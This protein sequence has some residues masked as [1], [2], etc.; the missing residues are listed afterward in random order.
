V[1]TKT[2][3]FDLFCGQSKDGKDFNHYLHKYILHRIGECDLGIN[4]KTAEEMTD[5]FEKVDKGIVAGTDTIGR[6][7]L[8]HVTGIRTEQE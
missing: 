8:L 7:A 6:L 1:L 5:A 4:A 3:L 2:S